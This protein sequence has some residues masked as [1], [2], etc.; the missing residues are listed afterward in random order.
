MPHLY[1][2]GITAGWLRRLAL[3]H[4]ACLGPRARFGGCPWT[5]CL[6]NHQIQ[7]PRTWKD[8]SWLTRMPI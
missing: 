3:H 4:P 6:P 2:A 1:C 8:V 7:G 5:S